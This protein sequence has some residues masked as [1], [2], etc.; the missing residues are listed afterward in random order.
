VESALLDYSWLGNVRELENVIGR[1]CM[2]TQTRM[3]DLED[4]PE[5]VRSQTVRAP[6]SASTL[7][8]AERQTLMQ[9]LGETKNKALAARRLGVSRARLYRLMEKYGLSDDSSAAETSHEAGG[10]S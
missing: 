1:A 7:E 10:N 4:L 2:L 9:I 6:A 8:Q 5:E 3:I